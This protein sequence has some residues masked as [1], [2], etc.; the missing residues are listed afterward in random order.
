MFFAR[1]NIIIAVSAVLLLAAIG[2]ACWQ[3]AYARPRRLLARA[4]S[5]M[6]ARPDSALRTLQQLRRPQWLMGENEALYAL[7][8]T[9]ACYK[10]GLPVANDSLIRI[11]TRHY[12]TAADPLRYA[13]SLFYEGQVAR[14]TGDRNGALR[15]FQRAELPAG[16]AKSPLLS[17]LLY[18]HW[19]H[20]MSD[21]KPYE[22][23]LQK[24]ETA[25]QYA[26]QLNDTAYIL[27]TLD[28]VSMSRIRL[29][30]YD[31]AEACARQALRLA[32]AAHDVSK[33]AG[34]CQ[35]LAHALT[36]TGKH[37]EALAVINK[38]LECAHHAVPPL[39]SLALRPYWAVKTDA[40]LHLQQYDSA[41]H[42][43]QKAG[44][45]DG[46]GGL[47][48]YHLSL[49]EIEKGAGNIALALQYHECFSHYLDSLTAQ[50]TSESLAALQKK[51]D[52]EKFQKENLQLKAER[53]WSFI[54]VLCAVLV[55]MGAVFLVLWLRIKWKRE[56]E[57]LARAKDLL[58][59]Q[60]RLQLQGKANELLQQRQ[61][62]QEKEQA[63]RESMQ[64]EAGLKGGLSAMERQLAQYAS[65]QELL[66][67]QLFK[68]NEA[69]QRIKEMDGLSDV[70][71][72]K[73]SKEFR[74]S[75]QEQADLYA[76]INACYHDFESRLRT[77]CSALADDDIYL[78]C[79]LRMGVSN[80][81]I[82]ILMGI[83]E[84]ALRTRKYRIKGGKLNVPSQ[85][86]SLEDFLRAF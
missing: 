3:L 57:A 33:Y 81:S 4:E 36:W 40:F 19:G 25:L 20:L 74:L 51:Y 59:E 37:E 64:R 22:E 8:M 73:R 12:A 70:Q 45:G 61:A 14:D 6:Q 31:E 44:V 23:G 27:N 17:F 10:N 7:L 2:T 42:Y 18:H 15:L 54:L 80:S 69:V 77:A 21:E 62:L 1:K 47:A 66:K 41:R 26:K 63:L 76:A 82:A 60:S 28:M 24:L 65:Q 58:L 30:Q 35:Q 16:Q 5:L 46:F 86:E 55:A 9:Q 85:Y 72:M 78:C 13:W 53:Q 79:L 32:E 34:A 38:A 50:K 49:Y 75:P 52:Y 11:A 68:T 67:K 83:G 29:R 56:K 43:T 39:D 84:G 48:A 71:K